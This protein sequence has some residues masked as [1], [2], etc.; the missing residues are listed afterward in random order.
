LI[1]AY[2]SGLT[3]H[4]SLRRRTADQVKLADKL[5][6]LLSIQKALPVGWDAERAQRY[7]LWAKTVTDSASWPGLS[8]VVEE[9]TRCLPVCA[10]ANPALAAQLEALYATGTFTYRG[11]KFPCLPKRPADLK[12][13]RH[14]ALY[15]PIPERL[16]RSD[17]P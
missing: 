2:R 12:G 8:V 13:S 11:K 3:D 4:V 6:N 7:F 16:L 17:E 5:H 14:V 9:L 15:P 1:L 10:P